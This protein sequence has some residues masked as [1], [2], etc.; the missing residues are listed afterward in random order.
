MNK[1]FTL[2]FLPILLF[3]QNFER[4]LSTEDWKFKQVD[5]TNWLSATVPGTV[6]TDL[7]TNQVIADPFLETNEK[8]VQWIEKED[9]EYKTS[10]ILSQS[11]F[12]F[13]NIDLQ[14]D[15]LDTYASVFLND[16]LVLEANNMFR[17]WKIPVR[18]YLLKGENTL[19][20]VFKSAVREEQNFAKKQSVQLPTDERVYSRKAP[21]QYGWD[22][23]PR[24]VTAGIWKDVKLH[25]WNQLTLVNSSYKQVQLDSQ[26]A[27]LEFSVAVFSEKKQVILVKVN[28]SLKKVE[29][30]KGLHTIP[31]I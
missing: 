20:V 25:F 4:P 6:H 1:Y 17:I 8:E 2:F 10:F 19:K 27:D 24:L 26:K 31:I 12:H 18:K 9:W 13:N 30:Q 14:F 7:L 16:Q 11:E 23:G 3:G 21:Y 15:G 28:D 29:L 5:K 22:W